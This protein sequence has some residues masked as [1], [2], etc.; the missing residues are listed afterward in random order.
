MWFTPIALNDSPAAARDALQ[1]QLSTSQLAN[2]VPPNQV[3]L[4][5]RLMKR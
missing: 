1:E 3:A 4:M 5:L 2:V